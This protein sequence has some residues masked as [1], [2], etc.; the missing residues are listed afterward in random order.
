MAKLKLSNGESYAIKDSRFIHIYI[1]IDEVTSEMHGFQNGEAVSWTK[2]EDDVVSDDDFQG[3]PLVMINHSKRGSFTLNLNDG[4]PANEL[5]YSAYYRQMNYSVE[6]MPGFGFKVQN[7][8][9]G[10]VAQSPTCLLTKMPDGNVNNTIG[11]KTW[12]VQAYEYSDTF[13][14]IA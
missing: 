14:D 5:V 3:N 4:S 7:D 2:A 10:E 8:N 6:E 11:P 1:T 13:E 12:V 9:N